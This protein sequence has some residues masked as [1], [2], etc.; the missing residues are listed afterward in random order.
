ME[1]Q[2]F[3]VA[4]VSQGLDGPFGDRRGTG[5]KVRWWLNR[6][7]LNILLRRVELR[8]GMGQEKETY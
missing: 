8:G 1:K 7:K 2:A 4:G 6:D 5:R 3:G